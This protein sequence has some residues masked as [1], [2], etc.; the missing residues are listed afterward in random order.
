MHLLSPH[1]SKW[2][3]YIL[4]A[5]LLLVVCVIFSIMAYFYTYIDPAEIEAQFKKTA[6]KEEEEEDDYKFHMSKLEMVK[7]SNP[8]QTKL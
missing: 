3:E 6:N 1:L 2:T 5:S 8:D 4:F 7:K